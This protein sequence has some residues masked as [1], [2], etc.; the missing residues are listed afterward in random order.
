MQDARTDPAIATPLPNDL[1]SCHALILELASSVGELRE[2]NQQ[3]AQKIEEQEL[4]ITRLLL[5]LRGNRSERVVED[6]QQLKLDFGD[7]PTSEEALIEAALE[8]ERIVQE[9]TVRRT[10]NKPKRPRNEQLPP[11]LPRYEVEAI[12]P[13]EVAVCPTHGPRKRIGVISLETLEYQPPKLRVRVTLIPKYACEGAPECGVKEPE[14]PQGLVEGN[15]YD[16][17]VAAEILTCKYA[18]HMPV[19][20]QED[21]FAG[22]GWTPGRSTLL[23]IQEAAAGVFRPFYEYYRRLVLKSA[24]LGTDDT[25]VTLLFPPEIPAAKPGDPRSQ[26]IH[27]V[28]TK[29]R[30]KGNT[31]VS[32]RM[33]AYRAVEMPINVFDFTVSRH[34]DGPQEFLQNY[35]GKLMA[36]CYSGYESIALKSDSR[37]QRG[38]CWGHARRK[39]FEGRSSHPLE[40]SV[41][42]AMIRELYDIEDRGKTLSA[43]A[44]QALRQREAQPVMKRIRAWLDSEVAGKVLP[45]SLF[46]E[47]L[48]YLRNHWDALQLYLSDGRMPIDNNDTEQL[49]KQ[50]AVGRKNWLFIGSVAAG[51]RAAVILTIVSTAH[52]NDLDVRAYLK[53]V[54]D[55]LLAGSTNYDSL[56]AD[57][58]KQSHPEHV[59]TYRAEER[60]DRADA[61]RHRRAHRRLRV[62]ADSEPSNS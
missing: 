47:A 36:D 26:R 55:Q 37:I 2:C 18:F 28:F 49:M 56:R 9:F 13:D 17:S 51:D 60:R 38:A 19:Y 3:R 29:A 10:R 50:V 4:V 59:R 48:R 12:V 16:T 31:S 7:Q 45:K 32:A 23:N 41:L 25:R 34:R 11:H 44:R 35:T 58:W 22:S 61:K 39:V 5:L 33:W 27:E 30:E 52:R 24:V 54:L 53:D 42:L 46:G 57:I 14:R 40:S 21:W 20:R 6:P 15:R 62:S 8:A 1:E 43:E